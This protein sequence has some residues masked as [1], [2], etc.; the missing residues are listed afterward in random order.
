MIRVLIV[1]DSALMRRIIY[2]IL[3]S[4]KEIEVVGRASNGIIAIDKIKSLKPDVVTMDIEMPEM[5]G[6]TALKRIMQD[7]PVPVVILSS[8][9]EYGSKQALEAMAL[10]AVDFIVKPEGGFLPDIGKIS[11]TIIKKVKAAAAAKTIRF[12]P[13][14]RI[15]H[16]FSPTTRK[17]IVIA[18]STGGP[19]TI[20]ALLTELPKNIPVGILIVQHMPPN[21]T[22]SFAQ[23]LNTICNIEVK[24][25]KEGDIV[26]EGCALIAPGGYHMEVCVEE[27]IVR[28]KLNQEPPELGVRPCANRLFR[29]AAAIYRDKAIGVVLTGMG[30]DGK[31]GCEEIKKYNGTV[32][33]EAEESCIIFGMPKSVIEANLADEIVRI[34]DMTVALIQILDT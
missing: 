16:S 15:A 13:G 26:S 24:E 8:H 33:A 9:S 6:I 20:E 12:E 3:K 11:E 27:T 18:S 31:E 1:D 21:F 17:V 10:G 29:S 32:I 5:D 28:V 25:A 30:N 34:Q 4:D 19:Q 2:D 14:R 7:C 23:R 22:A